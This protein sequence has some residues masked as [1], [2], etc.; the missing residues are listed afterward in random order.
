MLP[1]G[2]Q[3]LSRTPRALR[4]APWPNWRGSF[5]TFNLEEGDTVDRGVMSEAFGLQD[6]VLEESS[7][8]KEGEA[9]AGGDDAMVGVDD[10]YGASA[11][12]EADREKRR[13]AS[14]TL[15][16]MAVGAETPSGTVPPALV[17]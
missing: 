8:E 6:G 10:G 5:E 1:R 16:P 7:F 12:E 3:R 15:R 17:C 13:K 14:G 9:G 11:E 4:R 2:R